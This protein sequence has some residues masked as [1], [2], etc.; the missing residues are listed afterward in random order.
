MPRKAID[1]SK[2]VIYKIVCNDLNIKDIYVGSTTDF[3]SRKSHHKNSIENQNNIE[4]LYKKCQT[5]RDNGGWENWSMLEIEK[6]PCKDGN[7]GRLRERYW[8]ENLNATLNS[9][10]PI[11][12]YKNESK[13]KHYEKNKIE[14]NKIRKPYFELYRNENKDVI[15]SKLKEKCICNCGSVISIRNKARHIKSDYHEKNLQKNNN[16]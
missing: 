11:R 3:I 2:L 6:F 7:E 9:I 13:D 1:Y 15:T 5:I 14:I 4:Y 16:I 10:S 12:L 8:V